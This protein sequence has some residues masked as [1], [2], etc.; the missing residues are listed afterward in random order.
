MYPNANNS[1]V[2]ILNDSTYATLSGPQLGQYLIYITY[3]NYNNNNIYK[4]K[5]GE[6][7]SKA[8]NL[9]TRL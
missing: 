9:P 6:K 7:S 4:K 2:N 8:T 1:L 3:V 5:G